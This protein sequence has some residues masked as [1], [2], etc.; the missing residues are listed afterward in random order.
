[1]FKNIIDL[2]TQEETKTQPEPSYSRERVKVA[3]CVLMLEVARIDEEFSDDERDH[4]LKTLRERYSLSDADAREL[5]E[6]S[7]QTREQSVDV[8]Q[9]THQ[10]NKLCPEKEKIEIVEE[11]WRVVVADGGI[12]GNESH[13]MRKL[14]ALLNLTRHQIVDAK[15]KI[16]EEARGAG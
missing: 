10:I 11:V 2:F 6:V 9:F 3:A 15:V 5:L 4:I 13:F 8:W 16:L 1:M 14:G 7:T 12:H